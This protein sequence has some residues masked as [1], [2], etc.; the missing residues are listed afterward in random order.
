N[1][2]GGDITYYG[3][4][5]DAG[6]LVVV[7]GLNNDLANFW[8]WYSDGRMPLKPSADAFRLGTNVVLYSL[9]H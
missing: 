6:N 7:A 3:L 9:T 4:H 2:P 5:D 8:D 1:V